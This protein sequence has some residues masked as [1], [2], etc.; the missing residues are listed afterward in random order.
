[1]K[2]GRASALQNGNE[3]ELIQS[4]P[5]T[6]CVRRVDGIY[7][8]MNKFLKP[9]WLILFLLFPT[10]TVIYAQAESY[11]IGAPP[12][13]ISTSV[14]TTGGVTYLLVTGNLPLCEWIEPG[15]VTVGGTN[16]NLTLTEMRGL[17]CPDCLDCNYPATNVV[18]LG[19]L[20]GG[21][22]RLQIYAPNFSGSQTNLFRV[23]DFTIPTT[24]DAPL[25]AERDGNGLRIE[26]RG[27][28]V[29]NYVV[30]SSSTL[31]NWTPVYSSSAA[32][33]TFTNVSTNSSC[34]FYR[35]S[36]ASGR[37]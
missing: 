21:Q 16:I 13:S 35:A 17:L 11:P 24:N 8:F 10:R 37:K 3:R 25:V 34:R 29:A 36:I 28:A 33:F 20:A 18:V 19:N 2:T 4:C 1:M 6:N 12:L 30:E 14:I 23:I 32:P 31:T 22:D 5:K 27:L 7:I 26:V 15:P 9:L